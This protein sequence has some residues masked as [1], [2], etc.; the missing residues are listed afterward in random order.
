MTK[1][2]FA[3]KAGARTSTCPWLMPVLLLVPLGSQLLFAAPTPAASPA[4]RWL[5]IVETSR[6]TQT[7]Q[8]AIAQIA[9]NVVLAGMTGQMRAGDTLG[10]WTYNNELHAGEFPLQT[11]SSDTAQTIA[12]RVASFLGTRKFENRPNFDKTLPALGGVITNSEFITVILISSGT[13][14]MRGTAHGKAIDAIHQQWRG[15]QEKARL[16]FLTVLRAQRGQVTDF[17]VNLPPQTL[18]LPP[19]PAELL[20][21]NAPPEIK[22]VEATP[23]PAPVAPPAIVPSLIVHGKKPAPEPEPV[24]NQSPPTLEGNTPAPPAAVSAQTAVEPKK[25]ASTTSPTPLTTNIVM[26]VTNPATTNQ[27]SATVGNAGGGKKL[28]MAGLVMV[29]AGIGL[30]VFLI[31]RSRSEPQASLITRSLD[32]RKK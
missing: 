6:A 15:Q 18:Q 27:P 24:T 7:R 10:I 20:V 16:P 3:G 4:N 23:P 9:G 31:C 28:W 17:E 22:I 26:P 12:A 11:W 8:D 5:F 19:L 1:I 13:E 29:I 14:K 21:T 2:F 25:I 32:R 30:V